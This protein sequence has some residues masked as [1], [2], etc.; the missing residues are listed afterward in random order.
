MWKNFIVF[1]VIL[2]ELFILMLKSVFIFV[3]YFHIYKFSI[4]IEI[5]SKLDL[6]SNHDTKGPVAIMT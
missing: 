3:S 6:E 1:I 5:L 2:G 4:I